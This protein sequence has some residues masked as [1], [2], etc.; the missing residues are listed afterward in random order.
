VSYLNSTKKGCPRGMKICVWTHLGLTKWIQ[1]QKNKKMEDDLKN[2]TQKM[3]DD[4]KKK[5]RDDLK[6]KQ[7]NN[8]RRPTKQ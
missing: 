5:M 4:L 6:Q 7:K 8:G 2:K 3:K 1:P